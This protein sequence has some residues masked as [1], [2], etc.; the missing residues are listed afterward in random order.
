V[1]TQGAPR[2]R[3]GVIGVGRVG[4]VLA[5]AWQRAGHMV[6]RV[7]AISEVSLL[8]AEALIPNA[9]IVD[10]TDVSRD[11]DLVLM[12]VPDDVLPGLAAGLAEAG[13][14]TP[15]Q[16]WAHPAGRFGIDVL[17]PLTNSGA[18]PLALHPV[19]TFTG[20]SVDL[21]RLVDC[22]FGVTS[23]PQMRS[24]VEALVV[25]AGGDPV[26]V[27]EEAR[28]RY[29]AA[30]AFG[31]NSVS[32]ITVQALEILRS[33]GIE[34]PDHL[35]APLLHATIDNALNFGDRAI[36]GP[37]ARGDV[38]AVQAHLDTIS[39]I[40]IPAADAYRALAR[41]IADRAMA[42]GV[43]DMDQAAALLAALNRQ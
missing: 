22:P 16:F 38:A 11:S 8:R 39:D 28:N 24:V 21:T 10:V 7:S 1:N 20:T 30:L 42:S 5:A 14:V 37:V 33:A 31:S 13:A 2:L 27:P 40:S 6:H 23:D 34:A 26:W 18:I 12:A 9:Q 17:A 4:G 25:E 43:I 3:I 19:M 41:L 32:S 35:L 36:T 29:H 15:G